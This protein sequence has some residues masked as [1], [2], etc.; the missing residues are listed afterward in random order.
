MTFESRNARR[1]GPRSLTNPPPTT[2]ETPAEAR[3]INQMFLRA[4][5]VYGDAEAFVDGYEISTFNTLARRVMALSVFVDET[6]RDHVSAVVI[7]LPPGKMA[8][9]S[10]LGVLATGR[11]VRVID[12]VSRPPGLYGSDENQIEEAPPGL[13]IT[14]RALN[15]LLDN[16]LPN[17]GGSSPPILYADEIADR[18]DEGHQEQVRHRLSEAWHSA[19]SEIDAKTP[20]FTFGVG[21]QPVSGSGRGIL[22]HGEI[23]DL[24]R[25]R[26]TGSS[27]EHSSGFLTMTR[28]AL[29][30]TWWG[31]VLPALARGARSYV[32]RRFYAPHVVQAV[33]AGEADVL[34][35]NPAQWRAMANSLDGAA[36]PTGVEAWTNESNA[37]RQPELPGLTINS[38]ADLRQ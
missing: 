19:Y 33:S 37:S 38:L 18:L 17:L 8:V 16:V 29:D 32:I 26:I 27:E 20:A 35:L 34:T 31:A 10:V 12:A 14:F 22:N 11:H 36:L 7:F 13:I 9:A 28:L 25:A 15:R 21:G 6:S 30:S 3:S 4:W 5:R 24:V 2:T 1:S 23:M